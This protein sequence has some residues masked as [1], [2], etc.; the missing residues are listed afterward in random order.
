VLQPDGTT[1]LAG[2][3]ARLSARV[4]AV[5]G[6]IYAVHNTELNGRMAIRWYRIN[7]T[8][9]ALLESGTIADTNLDLFFPAIAANANGTVVI[10]CN[11]SGLST[12]V[13]CYAIAGQ[14]VKGVTTFG[15]LLLLQSGGTSYHGDDE[16]Y[17]ELLGLPQLSR[18][19]DYNTVSVDPTDS[20]RFWSIQMFPP[21]SANSDVWSTQITEL[22]TSQL[23]PQLSIAPAGTNVM[24]SWPSIATGFQLESAPS[25]APPI[26]WSSVTNTASTN[27]GTISVLVPISGSQTFFRLQQ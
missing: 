18:W 24:V 12:N 26:A 20:T 14:T 22:L 27:G 2:N 21:A 11:G 19:G 13:S 6:V 16:I 10:G 23:M 15:P 25:L 17:E 9:D 5:A 4:Y 1:T 3:D 7:A 8:N